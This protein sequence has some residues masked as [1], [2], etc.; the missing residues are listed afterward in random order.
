MDLFASVK[1]VVVVMGHTNKMGDIEVLK[2]FTLPLTAKAMV[3]K[4]ITNL[5][6]DVIPLGLILKEIVDV[7][8]LGQVIAAIEATVV[9]SYIYI[10]S[11]CKIW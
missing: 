8:T 3:D 7:V 5:C 1:H 2:N 6:V 9:F 10:V 4:I 11:C